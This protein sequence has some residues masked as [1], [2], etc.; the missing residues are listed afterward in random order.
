MVLAFALSGEVQLY[1]VNAIPKALPQEMGAVF[2]EQG[3]KAE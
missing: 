3:I 2:R 1:F